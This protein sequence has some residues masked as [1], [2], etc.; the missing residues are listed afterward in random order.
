MKE[1]TDEEQQQCREHLDAIL[2]ITSGVKLSTLLDSV[3]QQMQLS[4]VELEVVFNE[5]QKTV[6]AN[7]LAGF[8]QTSTQLKQ[9]FEDPAMQAEMRAKIDALTTPKGETKIE[10]PTE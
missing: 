5:V 8:A 6:N 9:L 10:V 3:V 7:I 4:G 2:E 1:L